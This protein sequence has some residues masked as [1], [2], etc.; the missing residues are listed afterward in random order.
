MHKGERFDQRHDASCLDQDL[1]G[2]SL[3]KDSLNFRTKKK[4]LNKQ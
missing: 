1:R 3:Q 2:L 4:K